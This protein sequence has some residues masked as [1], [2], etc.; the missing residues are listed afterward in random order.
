MRVDRRLFF[1]IPV[2]LC[3]V[4]T[5]A[6][7]PSVC[8]GTTSN[9]RLENGWNLP[10]NGANF[11]SYSTMGR[12]LGRTHV[13]S[14]VHS[15]VLRAYAELEMSLPDTVFVYGETGKKKGGDFEPHRTHEN[16]LSVDFMV[17]VRNADGESV[18]LPTNVLNKW[19]YDLEFDSEGRLEELTID[20]DAIAEHIYHLHQQAKESG[21]EIWRVILAPELQPYLHESHRWPYL[22]AN[23]Q[24]STQRSWV[25]HD[26]HYHV[27]FVVSC[28]PAS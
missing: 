13:H 5:E 20:F 24:F 7:E 16:G 8:F 6:R 27:D 2:L 26:E 25:R 9:G 14:W 4:S 11:Q 19:G 17:P 22:E 12:L 21:G 1:V 15:V 23:I 18:P 28:E 3:F 10:A